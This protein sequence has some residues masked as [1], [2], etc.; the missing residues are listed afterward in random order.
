MSAGWVA[1]SVRARALARRRL[2]WEATRR[3]AASASLAGALRELSGTPY[4]GAE[5]PGQTL[6]GAQH[7]IAAAVLSCCLLSR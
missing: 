1:G 5:T 7:V 3:L 6:A 2:C 4:G